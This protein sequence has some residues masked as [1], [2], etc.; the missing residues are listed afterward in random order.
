M[1]ELI[2]KVMASSN[3]HRCARLPPEW[4]AFLPCLIAEALVTLR[5]SKFGLARHYQDQIAD[6]DRFLLDH[7]HRILD[8]LLSVVSTI[9]FDLLYAFVIVRVDRRDL[10]WI[11]VTRNPTAEWVARQIT[12]AFP[13]DEAPGYMIRDRDRIYGDT[14]TRRTSLLSPTSP[15]QD[16]FAERLIRSIRRESLDHIVVFGE[17]NLRRILRSYARYYN[18]IRTYRSAVHSIVVLLPRGPQRV[19][20]TFARSMSWLARPSRTAFI[21]NIPK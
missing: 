19:R 1:P 4:R 16:G 18:D 17:A 13:W 9:G 15:W 6:Q 10:V 2:P 21:M 5:R 11:N 7:E 14:V 20:L 8:R 12:Q 3:K